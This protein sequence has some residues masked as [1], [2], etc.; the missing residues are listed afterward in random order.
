MASCDSDVG[1]VYP[2]K[3][4]DTVVKRGQHAMAKWVW[5]EVEDKYFFSLD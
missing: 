4:V 5:D 2:R 3:N 1:F